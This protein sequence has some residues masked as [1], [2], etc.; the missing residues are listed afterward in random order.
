MSSNQIRRP[1]FYEGQYLGAADLTTAIDYGRIEDARHALGA[2]TWGIAAGLEITE[3]DSAAGGG[4]VD[5]FIQPGYAWDGFGRPI[6]VPTPV[7][8]PAELFKSILFNLGQDGGT[9]PGHLVTV[10][11]RYDE[12]ATQSPGA[13][14]A[15]CGGAGEFARIG[16]TFR[17]EIGEQPGHNGHGPISV[18]GHSED[19]KD[20]L[21]ILNPPA[22]PSPPNPAP[23]PVELFDESIPYQDLPTD[24]PQARWAIP[25]GEVR[26]LP[27][28]NAALAGNFVKRNQADL[29]HSRRLRRHIGVVAGAVEAADGLIRLHNRT[30]PYSTAFTEDQ[31]L[32]WVEG[33]LRVR[34]NARLFD[35]KLEFRNQTGGKNGGDALYFSRRDDT[36]ASSLE[37]VIGEHN[38]GTNTFK[39][40]PLTSGVMTSRFT[41]LDNGRIGIGTDAPADIVSIEHPGKADL[42]IK[43]GNETIRIGADS[44]GGTVSTVSNND[45]HL[46]THNTEKVTI[47][48]DGKVGIGTQTPITKLQV[49]GEIALGVVASGLAP[50]ALPSG[51]TMCWNDG[52]WLRLNQNLDKGGPIISGGVHTPG[53]FSSGSLNVGGL[54]SWGDPGLG[55][56]WIAGRVGIGTFTPALT[57]DVQGDFGR[58]N[59]PATMSLWGSRIGD[60]GGG[61]LFIRAASTGTV[62][63][64]G[65]GN[66]VGIGNRAPD[67]ALHVTGGLHVEAGG[68]SDI[69]WFITSDERLK[70]NIEPLSGALSTLLQLRG[71]TFFWKQPEKKANQSGPQV[72]LIAQEVEKVLPQWII[73]G[74]TGDKAINFAGFEGLVVEALRELKSAIDGINHRLDSL[75]TQPTPN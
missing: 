69:G 15:R 27:N 70:K 35:G 40:G 42:T 23:P 63:F 7:K 14:F 55:N 1:S 30:T 46:S 38:A 75:E 19:A 39:I 57:L 65:F 41:V 74:P 2:H 53:R 34:G 18:A 13:G 52:D 22:P 66:R 36:G 31:E 51:T 5:V 8:I 29:N 43:A 28:T 67:S 71:V 50:L 73:E 17:I 56:V 25:L 58:Q 64:D 68:F 37:A 44:T 60:T 21:Q 47:K 6:V 54:N 59:G 72:G 9:P 12:S 20:I 48:A 24:N 62:A 45:L 3:K 49:E 11:L 33:D 16:E 61:I 10:W 32:V 4:Q 26:W